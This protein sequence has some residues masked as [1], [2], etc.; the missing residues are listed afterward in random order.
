M[1]CFS[2]N[3]WQIPLLMEAENRACDTGIASERGLPARFRGFNE[4]W[5]MDILQEAVITLNQPFTVSDYL[6]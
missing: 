6:I 1:K 5:M 4:D 3:F 2:V